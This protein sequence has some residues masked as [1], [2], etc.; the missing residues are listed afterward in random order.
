MMWDSLSV[1]ILI[2]GLVALVGI[3]SNAALRS[4]TWAGYGNALPSVALLPR[5]LRQSV[6][7]EYGD[8]V[9]RGNHRGW[10]AVIRLSDSDFKPALHI[11]LGV[12]LNCTLEVVSRTAAAGEHVGVAFRSGNARFD[13]TFALFSNNPEDARGLLLNDASLVAL[14]KLC[15]SSRSAVRFEKRQ[16]EVTYR[17]PPGDLAGGVLL[18]L[19]AMASLARHCSE[20]PDAA[21][22]RVAPFRAERTSLLVKAAIA[23][24]AVVAIATMLAFRSPAQDETKTAARGHVLS[25]GSL[26][27]SHDAGVIPYLDRWQLATEADFNPDFVARLRYAGADFRLPLRLRP[28]DSDAETETVYVLKATD[29]SKRVLII[30]NGKL[31]YD[32]RYQELEGVARVSRPNL[33]SIKWADDTNNADRLNGDG[34][35]LVFDPHDPEGARLLLAGPDYVHAR[36]VADQ[37]S[38][39]LGY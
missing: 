12:P 37:N 30:V 18:S 16:V 26:I 36:V 21:R 31:V 8:V 5:Q 4:R 38:V 17:T 32:S 39:I 19:D 25:D 34:L 3:I 13:Q 29:G 35:L 22:V 11:T 24:G 27:D 9:L 15:V 14:Q 1:S 23:V 10:P 6:T 7:R 2:V 20:L 28:T 33:G